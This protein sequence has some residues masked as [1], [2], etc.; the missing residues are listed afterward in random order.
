LR[1]PRRHVHV[2]VHVSHPPQ[3]PPFI[4]PRE[5]PIPIDVRYPPISAVL[6]RNEA[7]AA[8]EIPG[9]DMSSDHLSAWELDASASPASGR[10]ALTAGQARERFLLG[11]AKHAYVAF[12]LNR[13]IEVSALRPELARELETARRPQ[14][15][16][17]IGRGPDV[18]PSPRTP[19]ADVCA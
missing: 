2:N 1:L 14:L 10:A 16:L 6:I 13:P 17:R 19:L 15:V 5:S 3:R 11:A 9:L 18:P 7:R 4:R 12:Y 8:H